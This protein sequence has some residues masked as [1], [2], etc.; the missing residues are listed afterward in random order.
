MSPSAGR[1]LE[2]ARVAPTRQEPGAAIEPAFRA[3]RRRPRRRLICFRT[4]PPRDDAHLGGLRLY[5]MEK[6]R[7]DALAAGRHARQLG[8][9][10]F[11]PRD[12]TRGR[13]DGLAWSTTYQPPRLRAPRSYEAT[14]SE[15]RA[16]FKRT[17]RPAI[18]TTVEIVV[19]A[20]PPRRGQARRRSSNAE[21]EIREI[22]LTSYSELVLGAAWR[23]TTPTRCSR[24]CSSRRSF[25]ADH[26][27]AHWRR[28]GS[29][30][31]RRPRSV[32]GAFRRR[33]RGPRAALP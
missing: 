13:P 15:D 29:L 25:A 9:V 33:P 18:T 31:A 14:F 26:H 8:I 4:A 21:R 30:V 3:R 19:S 28:V 6:R 1:L 20:A 22:E 2:V 12:V 10:H 17:R 16:E 5:P 24:K 11:W 7:G 23:R 32:G 27:A